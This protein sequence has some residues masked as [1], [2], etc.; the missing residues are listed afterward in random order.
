MLRAGSIASTERAPATTTPRSTCQWTQTCVPGTSV[1]GKGVPT[2]NVDEGSAERR[3]NYAE[4]ARAFSPRIS[5]LAQIASWSW[6]FRTVSAQSQQIN[7]APSVRPARLQASAETGQKVA[8][9]R[10]S[11][12][13]AS[14]V[15]RAPEDGRVANEVSDEKRGEPLVQ[16]LTLCPSDLFGR[17]NRSRCDRSSPAPLPGHV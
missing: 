1:A 16:L 9:A 12:S 2:V 17:R 13:L 4:V 15:E 10:N 5:T 7:R 14:P 11:W 8:R 3:S 6:I